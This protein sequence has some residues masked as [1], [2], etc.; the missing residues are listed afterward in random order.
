[1]A[2]FGSQVTVIERG[3]RIMGREDPDAA[4]VVHKQME[5]D[6]VHFMLNTTIDEFK[7]GTGDTVAAHVTQRGI[8]VKESKTFIALYRANA[9]RN[10]TIITD[11]Y[12]DTP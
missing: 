12:R 9:R 6:G 8:K 2:L 1:M 11:V 4:A 10:C 3:N 7:L 5:R